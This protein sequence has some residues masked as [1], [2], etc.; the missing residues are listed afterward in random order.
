MRSIFFFQGKGNLRWF[1]LPDGQWEVSDT[2][3]EASPRNLP[4]SPCIN[5]VRDVM[6]EKNWL[7]F[8]AQRSEAWLDAAAHYFA[9]RSGLA[10]GDR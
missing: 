8:V 7:T 2:P 5:F 6:P 3:S 1:G 9:G 4:N 10:T